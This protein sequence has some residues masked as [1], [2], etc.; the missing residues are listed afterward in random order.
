MA[1]DYV[2]LTASASAR[3]LGFLVPPSDATK[4]RIP[5]SPRGQFLLPPLGDWKISPSLLRQELRRGLT[6]GRYMEP[7]A[8][9]IT[10]AGRQPNRSKKEA[11][12]APLDA[13]SKI[14]SIVLNAPVADVYA[15]CSRF[16]ELPR[17]ITS[18]RDVRKI[19]ETHFS[20]TSQLDG[21]EFRT[22]VQIVLRIPERRIAWQAMPDN[23]PRGVV[24][25]EPL[26][27]RTTEITVRLRSS[28]ESATLAK[29]TR[30]YLTNFKRVLER[31]STP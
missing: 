10:P 28:I 16:E 8:A 24:L 22:D 26:S 12:S 31:T 21:Q 5:L 18:L 17:F 23:F 6:L 30:D 7:D 29:V 20:F 4:R 25:F 27:N 1:Q 13:H 3:E 14:D 15:Y 11:E 9:D 19:D 2:L